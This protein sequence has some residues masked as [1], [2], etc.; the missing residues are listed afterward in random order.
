MYA[1][2]C[3]FRDGKS[4]SRNIDGRRDWCDDREFSDTLKTFGMNPS[5]RRSV[6]SQLEKSLTKS[7]DKLEVASA[8]IAKRLDGLS[9]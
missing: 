7:S 5:L 6:S 9:R 4:P 1:L 3:L 2:L 8:G